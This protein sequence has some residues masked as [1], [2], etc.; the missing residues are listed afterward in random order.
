L[1]WQEFLTAID[2]NREPVG[3]GDDGH[4]AN[5]MIE[6]VYRSARENRVVAI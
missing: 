5:R 1:E 4:Q 6:A 2:Q 3:S